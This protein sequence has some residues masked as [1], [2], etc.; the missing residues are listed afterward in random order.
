MCNVASTLVMYV[1]TGTASTHT[2][3]AHAHAHANRSTENRVQGNGKLF[4]FRDDKGAAYTRNKL[5]RAAEHGSLDFDWILAVRVCWT[6]WL[7][8]G[9][10][11]GS[12]LNARLF[13]PC[14]TNVCKL[15][16]LV[17]DCFTA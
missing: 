10:V 12:M 11:L 3:C 2:I 8:A 7:A 17:I 15:I 14:L 4:A 9:Y 1:C 5:F 6:P 16:L 13:F